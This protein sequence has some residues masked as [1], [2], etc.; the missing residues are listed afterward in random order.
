[1]LAT[2]VSKHELH[3]R[4][5]SLMQEPIARQPPVALPDSAGPERY[6]LDSVVGSNRHA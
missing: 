4:R 2:Q 3:G 1:M 6:A 5:N